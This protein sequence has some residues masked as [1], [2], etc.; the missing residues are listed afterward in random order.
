MTEMYSRRGLVVHRRLLGELAMMFAEGTE[1]RS[2]VVP[3]T[4]I[5]VEPVHCVN[6]QH[7]QHMRL[8]TAC[9]YVYTA[10]SRHI[11]KV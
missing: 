4:V 6:M 5:H 2:G 11:E 3:I 1:G 9:G 10:C 7:M 8:V